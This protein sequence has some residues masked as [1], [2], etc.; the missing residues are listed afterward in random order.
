MSDQPRPVAIVFEVS[1]LDRSER[2]YREAFGLNLHRADHES[3]DRWIGGEHAA[4]SWYEGSFIHFALYAAKDRAPTSRAQVAFAV[5]DLDTAHA[6]AVAAGA[7][8]VHV[9]MAQ[10]WGRSARYRD[11]DGNVIELTERND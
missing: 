1:G 2:L 10:P 8:V 9:P 4:C 3:G 5:D 7:E 6:R 11:P